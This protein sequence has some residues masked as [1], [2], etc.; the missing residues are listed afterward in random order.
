LRRIRF[1]R[2]TDKSE[3]ATDSIDNDF[4]GFLP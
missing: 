3:S 1:S 2:I 4:I